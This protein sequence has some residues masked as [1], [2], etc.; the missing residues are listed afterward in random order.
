MRYNKKYGIPKEFKGKIFVFD[1]LFTE[2]QQKNI[3]DNILD[4]ITYSYVDDVSVDKDGT[5]DS[6][7]I[8]LYQGRHGFFH[9]LRSDS[10]CYDGTWDRPCDSKPLSPHCFM[11]DDLYDVVTNK[12]N[13]PVYDYSETRIFFQLNLDIKDKDIPDTPHIDLGEPHL[14]MIYYVNDSDGDTIL[15]ENMLDMD[16]DS[17]WTKH[18]DKTAG[19][20]ITP[21]SRLLVEK[22]RVTPK[23]GRVLVFDGLYFHTAMQPQISDKRIIINCIAIANNLLWRH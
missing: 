12:I 11:V 3:L 9:T 5:S 22:K 6:D 17:Q 16:D 15:Y 1:D 10:H 18:K 20:Y 19:N 23:Q 21:A 13:F 7:G 8:V 14:S 4:E 2:E